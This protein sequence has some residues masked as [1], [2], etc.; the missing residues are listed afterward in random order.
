[1]TE[2]TVA[3]VDD[4]PIVRD[5]LRVFLSCQEGMCV[6]GEAATA[7]AAI[8]L[9][10]HAS[11]DVMVLDLDLP[12]CS[13][14]DALASLLKLR[15]KMAVLIFTAYSEAHYGI[16]LLRQGARAYLSKSCALDE[17]VAAIRALAAGRRYVTPALAQLLANDIDPERRVSHADLTDREWQVLLKLARGVETGMIAAQLSLSSDSVSAYRRRILDKLELTSNADIA[18][19]ALKHNLLF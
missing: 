13:G 16:R 6:I 3:V 9:A 8:D 2:I 5:A 17:L 18:Y 1:M 15:R 12:N 4:H 11:P 7:V 10:R 14:T 19:Y